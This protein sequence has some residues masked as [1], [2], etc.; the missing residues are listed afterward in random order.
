M[1]VNIIHQCYKNGILFL[2]LNNNKE[3][4]ELNIPPLPKEDWFINTTFYAQAIINLTSRLNFDDLCT[5]R[6]I[7]LPGSINNNNNINPLSPLKGNDNYMSTIDSC[8]MKI[9]TTLPSTYDQLVTPIQPDLSP[10]IID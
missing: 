3:R 6:V 1:L 4:Y 7:L 2:P 9:I 10:S 8:D 5:P